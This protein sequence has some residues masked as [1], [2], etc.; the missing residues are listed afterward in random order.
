MPLYYPPSAGASE[1]LLLA[2]GGDDTLAALT[3]ATTVDVTDLMY[4]VVDPAGTPL[5]RKVTVGTVSAGMR[6]SSAAVAGR[7]YRSGWA[8]GGESNS[9]GGALGRLYARP[10]RMT[11]G[12]LD[13]LYIKHATVPTASE[14]IRLGIYEDDGAG[15]PGALVLDAG[16]I[17]LST[18]AAIKSITISQAVNTNIYWLA[19]ARQGPTNSA[20]VAAF[21]HDSPLLNGLFIGPGW[22]ELISTT[23]TDFNIP[24]GGYVTGVT[25]ALPDPF[26]SITLHHQN[27][28]IVAW[29][30]S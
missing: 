22:H 19:S 6:L 30:Y 14:L 27:C 29:R 15:R 12:T 23:P 18:A 5:D 9:T 11:A 25:G 26:G 17:D 8:A 4:A 16:T 21:N 7:I 3:E 20:T 1:G 28:A 2:A 24:N 10:V 13:R